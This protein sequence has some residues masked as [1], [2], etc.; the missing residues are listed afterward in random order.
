MGSHSC[1]QST[2]NSTAVLAKTNCDALFFFWTN[3]INLSECLAD[4]VLEVGVIFNHRAINANIHNIKLLKL[5]GLFEEAS[6]HASHESC[7]AEA[8]S[9]AQSSYRLAFFHCGLRNT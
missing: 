3:S 6:Q 5:S 1:T 7:R 4:H 8:N 9:M 2:A